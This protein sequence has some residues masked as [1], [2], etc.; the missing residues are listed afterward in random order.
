MARCMATFITSN[1]SHFYLCFSRI[2]VCYQ[3]PNMFKNVYIF[4]SLSSVSDSSGSFLFSF[5][6]SYVWYLWSSQ[7]VTLGLHTSHLH[8]FC[9]MSPCTSQHCHFVCVQ[10]A[11]PCSVLYP[12]PR[13]CFHIHYN[14]LHIEKT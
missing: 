5:C 4:I 3:R 2:C 13:V 9:N 12:P 6:Y 10:E 1:N 7:S 14:P 8:Y 11:L